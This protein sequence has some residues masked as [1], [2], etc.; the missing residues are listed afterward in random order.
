MES[1]NF[2]CVIVADRNAAASESIR[3]LLES[4]FD[5]VYLV[6]DTATL[7]AGAERLLPALIV[8]DLSTGPEKLPVLLQTIHER[9]P[10]SHILVL[11][12]DDEAV[13]ARH[14]LAAGAEAVVLKR[15]A[16]TDIYEAIAAIQ[17]GETYLSP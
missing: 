4:E 15:C 3:G 10:R 2:N 6:A 13:V 14:A 17:R 7:T 11:S 5:N 8:L 9:S 12:L 16:G 1:Q